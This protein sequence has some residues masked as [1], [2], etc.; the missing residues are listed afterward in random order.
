MLNVRHEFSARSRVG[1]ELV[2]DHAPRTTALFLQK[3]SEQSPGGL[4]VAMNL[5]DFI[6]HITILVNG[7]PEIA[8]FAADRDDHFVEMPDVAPTGFLTLQPLSVFGSE[9]QGWPPGST[10]GRQSIDPTALRIA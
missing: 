6:K 9:F 1:A 8:L 3:A 10:S 7:A 2:G 4:G 5:H